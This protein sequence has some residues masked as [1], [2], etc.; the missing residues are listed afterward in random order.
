VPPLM[1]LETT[2]GGVARF[3]PNLYADGKVC[4]SLLGTWHGGDESEKWQPGTSTLF[5]VGCCRTP[6]PPWPWGRLKAPAQ[7]V[8]LCFC[9]TALLLCFS[10][11]CLEPTCSKARGERPTS[12]EELHRLWTY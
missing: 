11:G 9:G 4:L 7:G 6:P 12:P 5:Q 2:G 3:N 8:L 1:E 10:Q